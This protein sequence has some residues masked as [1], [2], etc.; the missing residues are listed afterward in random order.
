MSNSQEPQRTPLI[1]TRPGPSDSELLPE[2][3]RVLLVAAHPDDPEF[4]SGGT[5]ARWVRAGLEVIYVVAT[6]GDK[7]TLDREMTGERLSNMREDEQ[8]AAAARLGVKEV[9][10]LR[11]PD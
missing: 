9:I 3:K 10:F 4:S 8:R 1:V 6:S 7:G 5:V 2:Q 11:F